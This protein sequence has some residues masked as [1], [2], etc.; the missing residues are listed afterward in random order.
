MKTKK[1]TQEEYLQEFCRD[2]RLRKRKAIYVR[3]DIHNHMERVARGLKDYHVSL[4]SLITVILIRHINSYDHLLDKF[5]EEGD[6]HS[7]V[8]DSE[9]VSGQKSLDK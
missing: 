6:K 9:K 3:D 1:I 5:I 4:S 7:A 8:Q 2:L